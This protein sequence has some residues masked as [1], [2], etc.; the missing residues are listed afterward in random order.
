MLGQCLSSPIKHLLNLKPG[1]WD[2]GAILISL[3]S[4]CSARFLHPVTI[5]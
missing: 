1:C 2:L 3:R 5:P 4:T